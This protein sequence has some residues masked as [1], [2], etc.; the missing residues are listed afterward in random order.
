MCAVLREAQLIER[1]D[2]D[3]VSAK[4]KV[5]VK[6]KWTKAE[7]EDLLNLAKNKKE[8]AEKLTNMSA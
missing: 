4:C 6:G 7:K 5:R 1:Y 2:F 3:D 8:V